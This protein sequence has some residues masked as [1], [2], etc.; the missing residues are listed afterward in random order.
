MEPS[1]TMPGAEWDHLVR[2]VVRAAANVHTSLGPGYLEAIYHKGL[3]V[4]LKS[5]GLHCSSEVEVPVT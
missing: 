3:V 5:Q 1:V 4:E 2:A